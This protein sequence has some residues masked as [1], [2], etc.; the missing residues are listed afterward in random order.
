MCMLVLLCVYACIEVYVAMRVFSCV[1]AHVAVG[2]CLCICA[3]CGWQLALSFRC[4][5]ILHLIFE[6]RFLRKSATH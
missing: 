2:V 5:F 4:F 3:V 6:A 1:Y